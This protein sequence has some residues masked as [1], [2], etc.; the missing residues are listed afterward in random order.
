[1]RFRRLDLN[2]LVALDALL[3]YQ[4]VTRAAERLSIT[5]SGLSGSLARLREHFE[6]PLIVRVG[7]RNM[8]TPLA[9]T[10]V[11][12]VREM[13]QLADRLLDTRPS[14]DPALSDR[15]FAIVCSDYV[16]EILIADV[17][18]QVARVAPNVRITLEE[19]HDDSI[20][21]FQGGELE[22][23]IAREALADGDHPQRHLFDDDY[24]GVVW[25][26]NAE[27]GEALSAAQYLQLGHV[28]PSERRGLDPWWERR[29]QDEL[30]APRR[31]VMRAST[32]L[33]PRL[34]VGTSLVAVTHARTARRLAERLDLRLV[35]LPTVFPVLREVLCWQP[36]QD[37]DPA[38]V[39][40]RHLIMATAAQLD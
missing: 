37:N 1:M 16:G 32:Q 20:A 26:K 23:M 9:L 36:H 2:L 33:A 7:R 5:Q 15:H 4:H 14:F 6:D 39:W 10:L 12:P 22:F 34:V 17:V 38:V 25:S 18:G 13:L 3:T 30:G 29:L 8:L 31:I 40:L 27:V 35:K 21:R 24:V 19:V 11:Q 28:G